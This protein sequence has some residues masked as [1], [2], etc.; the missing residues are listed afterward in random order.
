[1]KQA[2]I[3]YAVVPLKAPVKAQSLVDAVYDALKVK[4]GASKP[5]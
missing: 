1:M 5:A 2:K 4:K 3:E